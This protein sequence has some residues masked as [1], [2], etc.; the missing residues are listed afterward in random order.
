MKNWQIFPI[1]LQAGKNDPK[2]FKEFV[3]GPL[4]TAWLSSVINPMKI[5]DDVPRITFKSQ[6]I[7]HLNDQIP[8]RED[9]ILNLTSGTA[10]AL[11][12]LSVTS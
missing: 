12:C 5:Y 4:C 3:N 2:K 10:G 11:F 6:N 1:R 9:A 8:N 7:G